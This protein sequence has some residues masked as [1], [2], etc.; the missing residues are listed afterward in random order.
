MFDKFEILSGGVYF[1]HERGKPEDWLVERSKAQPGT[2][3]FMELNNHTARTTKK[4]FD[5]FT[6]GD[7]YA[8]D[9]TIVPV[10]LAKYGADELVSRS[11]AK[12]LLA[13]VELFKRVVFDFESVDTIGQAFADQ[14]FRVFANEHPEIKLTPV[15]MSNAVREMISRAAA[16]RAAGEFQ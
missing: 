13:R 8:F 7:D 14:I 10:N 11:Q 2:T 16:N 15:N 3:V 6:E 9:K 1:S 5:E 4:V 12:R